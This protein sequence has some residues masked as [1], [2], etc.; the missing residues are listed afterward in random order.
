[1]S[2]SQARRREAREAGRS[3][4]RTQGK[5]GSG[6]RWRVATSEEKWKPKE[7][8]SRA[9]ET[10]WPRVARAVWRSAG[11]GRASGGANRERAPADGNREGR[12]GS[13][14]RKTMNREGGVWPGRIRHVMKPVKDCI[15]S[16][17]NCG[18]ATAKHSPEAFIAAGAIGGRMSVN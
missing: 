6:K 12:R 14:R 11:V 5:S 4:A 3:A 9:A 16:S 17:D 18:S 8:M 10:G 15:P 1:M 2:D 13:E 7:E